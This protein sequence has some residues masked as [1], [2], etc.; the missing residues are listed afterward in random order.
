MA[1]DLISQKML[2]RQNMNIQKFNYNYQLHKFSLESFK[3]T[4]FFK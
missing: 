4:V 1:D 2:K 3:V